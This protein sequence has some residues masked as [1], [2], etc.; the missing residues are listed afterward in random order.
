MKPT[1]KQLLESHP[2]LL[3]PVAH[4]ALTA[5]IIEHQGF[6]ALQVGGFAVDATRYGLPDVGLTHYGEKSQAVRDILHATQIPVMVD[7]DN[8]YGDPK[9]ITH[10]IQS[11]ERLGAAAIFIEDQIGAKRCGHMGKHTIA[12]PVTAQVH[13]QAAINARRNPDTFI[14][15]RTDAYQV[16]GLTQTLK[17]CD[18]Y[19][20]AG[21]DGIY[22]EG[23][24]DTE[25]LETAAQHHEDIPFAISILEGG[26]KTPWIPPDELQ[27]M[28]V[29]M[30][31][32][33]TTILFQVTHAIRR[34]LET[35]RDGQRSDPQHTD[36]MNTVEALLDL[37][38]WQ[39]VEEDYGTE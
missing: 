29:N 18:Q 30:A 11:Y 5:K 28:G 24:T 25:D 2:L 9:T 35:L 6:P 31:L 23:I 7:A 20:D 36:D 19:R 12:S 22:I 17:R 37:K 16:E 3:L 34:A 21:A 26:G 1:W 32:Y 33:P 38:H 15:A 27:E 10:T 4:D 13:I 8:G 39:Q 14:M